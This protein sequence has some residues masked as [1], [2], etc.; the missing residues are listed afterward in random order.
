MSRRARSRRPGT[1]RTRQCIWGHGSRHPVDV[2]GRLVVVPQQPRR[3]GPAVPDRLRLLVEGFQVESSLDWYIVDISRPH[4]WT[5]LR[6]SRFRST[7]FNIHHSSR[8]MHRCGWSTI[9]SD[10]LPPSFADEPAVDLTG[11]RQQ[12]ATHQANA[13]MPGW[14]RWHAEVMVGQVNEG[15]C[16][17]SVMGSL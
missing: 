13:A 17:P 6:L 4:G 14:M 7:V 8:V 5:A 9:A 10:S 1:Q 2:G 16:A 3:A 11:F 12:F 15:S